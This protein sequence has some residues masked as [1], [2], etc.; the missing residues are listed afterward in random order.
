MVASEMNG[1]K[2][3]CK[4]KETSIRLVRAAAYTG[5]RWVMHPPPETMKSYTDASLATIY[6]VDQI[7]R[8][9]FSFFRRSKAHF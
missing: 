1:T 4:A 7:K 8:G 5:G 9:Q 2:H 6:R 3:F